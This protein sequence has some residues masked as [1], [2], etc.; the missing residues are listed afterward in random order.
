MLNVKDD[1]AFRDVMPSDV[2]DQPA[3]QMV[4]DADLG[5]GADECAPTIPMSE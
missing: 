4:G 3:D 5:C 2:I 1:I